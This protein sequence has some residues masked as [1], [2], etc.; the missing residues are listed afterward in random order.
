MDWLAGVSQETLPRPV[1]RRVEKGPEA[2]AEMVLARC[3]G[4]KRT[5]PEIALQHAA[6]VNEIA[7]FLWLPLDFA[8]SASPA[9]LSVLMNCVGPMIVRKAFG[10]PI[11]AEFDGGRIVTDHAWI[12]EAVI[13]AAFGRIPDLT[14]VVHAVSEEPRVKLEF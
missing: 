4:V 2:I 12:A 8:P 14:E 1:F 11:V 7:R 3:A 6:T 13:M 5:S 9:I 10:P